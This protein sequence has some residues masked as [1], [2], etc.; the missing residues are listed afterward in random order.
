[1]SYQSTIFDEWFDLQLMVIPGRHVCWTAA[2]GDL[3]L[4]WRSPKPFVQKLYSYGHGYQL[5]SGN[6]T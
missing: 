3:G 6:L 5:P 2:R 1:M 4:E